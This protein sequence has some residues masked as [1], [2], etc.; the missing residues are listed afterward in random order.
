MAP[1]FIDR[2]ETYRALWQFRLDGA[3]DIERIAHA[4]DDTRFEDGCRACFCASGSARLA[5]A[6][7]PSRDGASGFAPG[8]GS[9]AT[10]PLEGFASAGHM[11]SKLAP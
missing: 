10:G 3:I 2:G 5:E 11:A 8:F 1:Q 7:R 4:V 9:P 6:A